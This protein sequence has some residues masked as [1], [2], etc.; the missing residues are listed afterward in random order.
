MSF[1]KCFTVVCRIMF[2][3][4]YKLQRWIDMLHLHLKNESKKQHQIDLPRAKLA[5]K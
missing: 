3:Q 5:A 2:R 4:L 1:K